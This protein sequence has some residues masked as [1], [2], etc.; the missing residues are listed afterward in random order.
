M[1]ACGTRKDRAAG[2]VPHA[3][4]DIG[5]VG[6]YRSQFGTGARDP[7]NPHPDDKVPALLHNGASVTELVAIALYLTDLH[8]E[9]TLGAPVGSPERGAY[10]TWH[11]RTV[12]E[13]A[14]VVWAKAEQMAHFA[15]AD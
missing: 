8:P 3:S 15:A 11:L 12:G 5:Q 9:S 13:L 10:L 4:I 14:P 1:A 7:A 6:L 2:V